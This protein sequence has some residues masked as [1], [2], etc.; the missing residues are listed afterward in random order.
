MPD[1]KERP[2]VDAGTR[3]RLLNDPGR[4]GVSKG[5]RRE[6]G[7]RL[8]LLVAFPERAEWIPL[9][10]IEG[11]AQDEPPIDLLRRG[12]FARPLDLYRTLTHIRLSG[13][14]VNFIYSLETTGTDFYAYQFKPVLKLLQ[15][16]STGILIADEV[17]LGKT[18][19]AGLIWTEL[20]SRF[21]MQR[22]LV[23]CPAMLREKWAGELRRRFGVQAEIQDAKELLGTLRAV[24]S[25]EASEFAIVA[26]LQG[27]RPPD[28]WDAPES[29]SPRAELAQLLS[30]HA[31]E[32]PLIDLLVIDEAHALRNPETRTAELGRLVRQTSQYAVLLSATPVHLRSEDLFHLLTVVDDG[33]FNQKSVFDYIQQANARLVATRDAVLANQVTS[34]E[35]VERLRQALG[36][37]LLTGNRQMTA[38]LEEAEAGADLGSPKARVEIASRIEAANLLGYSV[39]RTRRRDVKELRAVRRAE[40]LSVR[41]SPREEAFYRVVTSTVRRWC[42]EAG[43]NEGFV[44]CM[45]QRQM[46][47]SMAGALWSWSQDDP[48]IRQEL[49]EDL[50]IDLPEPEK[51]ILGPLTTELG[52]RVRELGDLAGLTREDTKY[53]RFRD[54]LLAFFAEKPADKV[55][56]FSSFRHTLRYLSERLRKDGQSTTLLM[57]G[58]SG[59]QDVLDEFARPEGPRILLSSEV[60][61]EGIDLQFAWV[62]VNYDLPWNPMRVEQRIGRLDRLGQTSPV[63]AVWNLIHGDTIDERIYHRLLVRLGIFE[64]SLGGL[65]SILGERISELTRDLLS[66]NLSPDEETAR[67]DQ[68]FVALENIQKTEQALEDEAPSLVAYGDFILQQ[69]QAA[70][71]LARRIDAADLQ[72]Y[73]IDFLG[74]RYPGCRFRQGE[75]DKALVEVDLSP[76]CK[77]DLSAFLRDRRAMAAS[78]LTGA[79]PVRCRFDNRM[80]A[81]K[82]ATEE[83]VGQLHPL[84]RFAASVAD[85]E[86]L[87]TYPAVAARIRASELPVA[88]EPGIYAFAAARWTFAALRT[89]EQLWFGAEEVTSG[90][91]LTESDAERLVVCI[92]EKGEDWPAATAEVDAPRVADQIEQGLLVRAMERFEQEA[93]R[94]RDQ[95]EDRADAQTRSLEAHV[96]QQR[97][98]YEDLKRRHERSG[99][100]GLAKA[101]ETNLARLETRFE[102]QR[103]LIESKR[104]VRQSSDEVGVGV[105]WVEP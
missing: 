55:V 61:A 83:T 46:A 87:V 12:R 81:T 14:L 59:R 45:P 31:Q 90:G 24:S 35:L 36:H 96:A 70:Q 15:S 72:R 42:A 49:Y 25:G 101:Q 40:T 56:V 52:Q 60:G 99:N 43:Q 104:S 91:V 71:D 9:D 54:R 62:I 7:N 19:E 79:S 98:K 16:V 105:V 50:G 20:R 97:A 51:K 88:I 92:G 76:E 28:E 8:Y 11:V 13:R 100:R 23:L 84:V 32:D 102:Q 66:K 86:R 47:S 37:P 41:M 2:C 93:A 94:I 74:Q 38:L 17:G 6:R 27:V 75:E 69:V 68:T 80:H 26:S 82:V 53:A 1:D 78:R 64:A 77:N 103:K 30:R 39:T 5:E 89:S 73:V 4:T 58:D 3:V 67:I 18:I 48:D 63:I 21:D 10:Q 44:L 33:V 29:R 22:L 57:G 65:E 95:N 85:H 34:M